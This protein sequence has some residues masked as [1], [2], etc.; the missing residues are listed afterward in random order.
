MSTCNNLKRA[1]F[2]VLLLFLSSFASVMY[3]I[4][5]PTIKS[6]SDHK[7]YSTMSGTWE[8]KYISSLVKPLLTVSS[9]TSRHEVMIIRLSS[10]KRLK[11]CILLFS[12]FILSHPSFVSYLYFTS[13]W[14]NYQ[15]T[16]F[17]TLNRA[18]IL[19]V[20]RVSNTWIYYFFNII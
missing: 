15:R 6:P 10:L 9:K 3:Q 20:W 17:S 14:K 7:R 12:F 1:Y 16:I 13:Y 4:M 11:A 18:L 8:N 19:C 5:I 2:L